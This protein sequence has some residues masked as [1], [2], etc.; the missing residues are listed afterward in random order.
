MGLAG[1]RDAANPES[2]CAS[3]F[4]KLAECKA[5]LGL[6]PRQCYNYDIYDNSCDDVEQ[7][8]KK[9]VSFSACRE[10]A[11]IFYSKGVARKDKVKASKDLIVCLKQYKSL[12]ECSR[13]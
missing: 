10:H 11:E 7:K 12:L 6:K 9:C 4:A 3:D 8:L 5:K 13:G 2:D 1:S